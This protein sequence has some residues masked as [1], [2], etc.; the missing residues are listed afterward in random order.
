MAQKNCPVCKSKE[1][2]LFDSI[3]FNKNCECESV[4]FKPT[5]IMVE[6]YICNNCN[7]LYAPD[8]CKW[9][10]KKFKQ[11]I[12]NKKYAI[13]DPDYKEV[14]PKESFEFLIK[15][16]GENSIAIRH[17]DYGGGNG[18]LSKL[19]NK[20]GVRSTNFE[21]F[22]KKNNLPIKKFNLITA[23]EVFEHVPDPNITMQHV[24]KL[25]ENSGIFIVSTQ[26]NDKHIN[27][28]GNLTWWYASPRNGHISLFSKKSI[29]LLAKKHNFNFKILKNGNQVFW[30][31]IP[32]WARTYFRIH[33]TNFLVRY[34]SR[35]LLNI[36]KLKNKRNNLPSCLFNGISK[37]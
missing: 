2:S 31:E 4:I 7:H 15:E 19:M 20:F 25:I 32:I 24:S 17:L 27:D 37:R 36:N 26:L 30:R 14:R 13:C 8:I 18:K 10:K 35:K 9:N 5:G 3:D 1:L 29:G 22:S 12:Y 6:Y 28:K 11:N 21:P 16:F 23:F 34:I 33:S